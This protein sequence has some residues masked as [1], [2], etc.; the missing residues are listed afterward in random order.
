MT[1]Y[2]GFVLK[3][4]NIAKNV[5]VRDLKAVLMERGIK[6]LYAYSF[7]NLYNIFLII[8]NL[9]FNLF[10]DSSLGKV[11]GVMHICILEILLISIRKML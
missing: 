6:P 8:H 1:S 4:N 2:N 3:V 10:L 7:I 9:I 11:F 5:T